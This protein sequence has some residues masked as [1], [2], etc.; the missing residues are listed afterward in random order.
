MRRKNPTAAIRTGFDYQDFWGLSLFAEWLNN[1]NKYKWIWFETAPTEAPGNDFFLDDIILSTHNNQYHLYQIKHKQRPDRDWWGW[2]DLFE[3]GEGTTGKLKDSLVQ[4]WFHSY[5]KQGL[6]GKVEYAAFV[7]N[8]FPEKEV[9][10]FIVNKRLDIEKVKAELPDL[11]RKIKAQ[12]IDEHRISEFFGKFRFRFGQKSIDDLEKEIRQ[13]FYEVLRATESGV[14]SLLLQIHA[15]CRRPY[16]DYIILDQIRQWCEFDR[17]RHLNERFDIPEDFEFFD[18][19]EHEQILEDLQKPSGGVKVIFG[20]PGAGKSTYLSKLH[21]ILKQKNTIT[22][23][24]HYHI[25][26]NDPSPIARLASQRV[27]EA[28]KAQFKEHGDKLGD[29]AHK[30]SQN[31]SL[32]EYISQLAQHVRNE[33]KPFVLIIDGLD[34]VMRYSDESELKAFLT[35]ICFPQTGLWIIFGMQEIAK[36]YLPQ[37]VFDQLP[38][39]KWLEIYGLNRTAVE[40]IITKNTI[41]L[42]L[43]GN[44]HMLSELIEKI[45]EITQGNPLH[46]RYSLQQLKNMAHD[47]SPTIIDCRNLLPYA[48]DIAN[49]YDSLW[50]QLPGLSQ[51][52]AIIIGSVE[53]QFRR[54][55]LFD[56]MAS[57]RAD[58]TELSDG[59]Q[60]VSHVMLEKKKKLSVYHNSFETFL[61]N[62]P[63]F[64]QQEKTIKRNIKEWLEESEY[65][66]LKWAEL[67]KLSYFLGDPEPILEIGREWLIDAICNL[68]EPQQIVSQ[69]ELAKEAAFKKVRFGKVLELA[70][71]DTYY[72]NALDFIE[73]PAGKIW[74]EAFRRKHKDI[75]DIDLDGLSSSQIQIVTQKAVS[76]GHFEIIEEAVDKLREMHKDLRIKPKGE[77]GSSIPELVVSLINTKA[78]DSNHEVSRIHRYIKQFRR[79]GWS[80]ELFVVYIDALL[81]SNQNQKIHQFLKLEFTSAEN[82]SILTQ[83]ARNDLKRKEQHF[84][85][86]IRKENRI[87][88]NYFCLMYLILNGKEIGYLP[89]LPSCDQFPST[90]PEHET[91]KRKER[92]KIFSENFTLGI[93]YGL[94][95]KEAEVESWIAGTEERWALGMMSQIFL[96]ALDVARQIKE[97]RTISLKTIFDRIINIE[98]LKWPKNRSLYEL[99]ICLSIALSLVMNV[100]CILKLFSEKPFKLDNDE[101][102]GILSTQ[103]YG[104][105]DFLGFLQS[106][107]TPLLSQNAYS[108]YISEERDMWRSKITTFPER[109][110]H[111]ADLAKL[112]A[113]NQDNHNTSEFL[114]LSANNLLGYGYRKDMFLDLVLD[115]IKSCH[116]AGSKNCMA[117]I[118]RIAPLIENVTEYTDGSET[119][120][121][122]QNLAEAL[123]SL[124]PK[125]LFRYYFQKAKDE[126]LFL[127]QNIFQHVIIS[128]QF[129]NDVEI[130]LAS[131]ALDR[132]SFENLKSISSRIPAAKNALSRIEDCFGKPEYPK[133]DDKQYYPHLDKDAED[134]SKI[135]PYQLEMHLSTIKDSWDERRFL[136]PYLKHWSGNYETNKKDVYQIAISIIEKK[137][138]HHADGEILDFLYPFAYEFDT[139]RAFELLCW[140]Q[141]NDHGWDRH[142][143]YRQRAEQ[144]WGF[145]EKHYSDR[146]MEFFEKSILYS[147]KQYGEGGSYFIPIPRGIDFLAF[148]DNLEM[149]EQITESSVKSMESLIADLELPKCLWVEL[150]E[151]PALDILFQR[152]MWPSPL[153]RER[154]ASA[155]AELLNT[156]SNKEKVFSKLLGWIS[157][158]KL[159]SV[160]AIGLL[161]VLKAL[162]KRDKI[163]GDGDIKRLIESLPMTS[164]VIEKLIEEIAHLLN[165]QLAL[166]SKRKIMLSAP[167]NYGQTEFFGNY[168]TGFLAPIYLDR[169]KRIASRT[170]K[171]FVKHWS[172]NAEMMAKEC[173]L[174]LRVRNAMDFMGGHNSPI[175][176]GM[177]TMLSEVYRSAFLRVLQDFYDNSMKED[178]F[179]EYAYAT[180]PV[181]LSYWKVKPN[182]VPKWWPKLKYST[183]KEAYSKE[184]VKFSYPIEEID[185]IIQKKRKTVILGIHG[186]I[187]PKTGWQTGILDTSIK[188]VGFGY[189]TLGPNIPDAKEVAEELLYK[190]ST[191]I[192]PTMTTRPFNFLESFSVHIQTIVSPIEL[193]DLIFYPLLTTP[194]DLVIGLWQWFRDYHPFFV[195]HPKLV[196]GFQ[197]QLENR[198]WSYVKDGNR[199]AS[200]QDWLEGLKERSDLEIPH[201]TYIE[202]DSSFLNS[203]LEGEG[204]RLGYVSKTTHK[205]RKYTSDK[206]QLIEDYRLVGVSKIIV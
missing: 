25:S 70:A 15:E 74:E 61:M 65:E 182:R 93:I 105:Y 63:E 187:Q 115:S 4:K 178:F 204:L 188:L 96:S 171:N 177:S 88:L 69:L 35:N 170:G 130:A 78:L 11:F 189:K 113:I 87:S 3:Q 138:I 173:G 154:A 206:G 60:C 114:K 64:A 33:K 58:P 95:G 47:K 168:I 103:Y 79:T 165:K 30:N 86:H 200:S 167:I 133:G 7:T 118:K 48:G 108:L 5:F 14:N 151:V 134:Y 149:I 162:E 119:D 16:T 127:S 160:I 19:L 59:F 109:A 49:Y 52:I 39:E 12:L 8:G 195:L 135:E 181:E 128:L 51:T 143:S 107:D 145:L 194:S 183:P 146:Y 152:L 85:Q 193:G 153:V 174:E 94:Q 31:V 159:E 82:L 24:H 191:V 184:I 139:T 9:E 121:F 201:G 13:S 72:Q 46:L 120:Y 150:P 53:F 57:F 99:Q 112:A 91:G 148:F 164:I 42:N 131:T 37:F 36:R 102:K 172:Y 116:R 185:Q 80:E 199:V 161:P 140:A 67:R 76:E 192:I 100:V 136:L 126:D 122:P 54:E 22:I 132:G 98:P 71:L 40:R 166:P 55:Q 141:A 81:K 169:A 68:R 156:H 44:P 144:R 89:P 45:F 73:E 29:L 66:E 97:N 17:P 176:L 18:A 101:V 104:R 123:V 163:F 129:E 111:Y 179:L 197:I 50:R 56:L 21:N 75:S 43:P 77:I 124:N 10:S 90:V 203:Y 83:C 38:E 186:T 92:A 158:Q 28:I 157:K 2:K 155:I 125:S 196:E 41:D 6:K 202:V 205:Y 23:R 1:P 190:P 32:Q 20:K 34:H 142:P 117:W 84:L 62:Q 106:F 175:L 137:G 180:L 198:R 26:P 147:G 110:E 27:I